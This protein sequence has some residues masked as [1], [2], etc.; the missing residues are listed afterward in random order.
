MLDSY[1]RQ[2]V[3]IFSMIIACAFMIVIDISLVYVIGLT[4][5]YTLSCL[6]I[7]LAYDIF[8]IFIHIHMS[9]LSRE[10]HDPLVMKLVAKVTSHMY[11]S[12]LVTLI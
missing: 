11:V 3:V 2:L 4:T 7:C 8:L 12:K 1:T 6:A 5:C 10:S 9:F